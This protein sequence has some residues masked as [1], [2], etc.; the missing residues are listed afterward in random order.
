MGFLKNFLLGAAAL[1]T[2]QNV[3]NRPIVT[4]PPG[5]VI[6]GMQQKGLGSAWQVSYS[7]A[8][9]MNCTSI[10]TISK[11]TRAYSVGSDRFTI[12]WP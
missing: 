12:D 6:R 5:F 7:K 11:G 8:S 10:F 3:Y 4:P 9:Q 2:Y 1:K